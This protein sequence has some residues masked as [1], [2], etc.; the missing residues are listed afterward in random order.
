MKGEG[1]QST[2]Q[3]RHSYVQSLS[4]RSQAVFASQRERCSRGR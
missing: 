4:F 1:I 3:R 2:N